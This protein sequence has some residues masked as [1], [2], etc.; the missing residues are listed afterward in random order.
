MGL[1]VSEV[2]RVCGN[3]KQ[4]LS[5]LVVEVQI[6]LQMKMFAEARAQSGFQE[7]A[8]MES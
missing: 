1:Q 5:L 8:A 2:G 4:F 6:A 3:F 7:V